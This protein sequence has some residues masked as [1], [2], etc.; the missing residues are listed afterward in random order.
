MVEHVGLRK[1]RR[2]H[3]GKRGPKT[4]QGPPRAACIVRRGLHPQIDIKSGPHVTVGGERMSTDEEVFNG[5]VSKRFQNFD[6]MRIH[7]AKLP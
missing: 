2:V 4:L 3:L 7:P 1:I 6:K 5:L